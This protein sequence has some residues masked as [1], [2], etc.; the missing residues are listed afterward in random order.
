M[1]VVGMSK[2][3]KNKRL[4]LENWVCKPERVVLLVFPYTCFL[5]L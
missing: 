1:G 5:P 3:V 4:R 2:I